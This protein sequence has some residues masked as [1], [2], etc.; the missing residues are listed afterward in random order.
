MNISQNI[1]PEALDLPPSERAK[2]ELTFCQEAARS[3]SSAKCSRSRVP[4]R[5]GQIETLTQVTTVG[6]KAGNLES[7]SEA[8]S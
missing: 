4:Q 7:G 6:T 1:C 2:L 3:M 8:K 5:K